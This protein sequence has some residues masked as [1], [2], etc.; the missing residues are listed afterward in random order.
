MFNRIMML[1][2]FAALAL[3][4]LYHS[5]QYARTMQAEGYVQGRGVI[6][7]VSESTRRGEHTGAYDHEQT[8]RFTYGGQEHTVSIN[9]SG[10]SRP[11]FI[12]KETPLLINTRDL[13]RSLLT[14]FLAQS[15]MGLVMV[16][17][18]LVGVVISLLLLRKRKKG[19]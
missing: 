15:V 7:A 2:V 19:T 16:A 13:Q 3:Y 11:D 6:I 12:G 17:V 10:V 9:V 14:S 4:G 5:I 8:V 18:G 1:L